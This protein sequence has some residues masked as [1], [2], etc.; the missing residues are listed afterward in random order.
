MGY[1]ILFDICVHCMM[2]KSGKTFYVLKRHSFVLKTFKIFSSGP[3]KCTIC[4]FIYIHHAV[5]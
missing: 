1:H 4:N 3:L 5:Q 2:F